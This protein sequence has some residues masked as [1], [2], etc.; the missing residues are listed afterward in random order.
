[1]WR[2]QRCVSFARTRIAHGFARTGGQVNPELASA[3]PDLYQ[4]LLDE[5]ALG[6]LLSDLHALGTRIEVQVK[7]DASGLVNAAD[8]PSLAEAFAALRAGEV[9]AVQLR[10]EHQREAWSD[11]LLRAGTGYRIVRMKQPEQRMPSP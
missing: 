9:R 10:Y 8:Q 1:M 2:V 7:R 5:A 3:L 11:T 6:A 4:G